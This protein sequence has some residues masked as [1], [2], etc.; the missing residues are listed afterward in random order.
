MEARMNLKSYFMHQQMMTKVLISLIPIACMSVWLYGWRNLIVFAVVT[1]AAVLAEYAVMHLVQKEKTKVTE[2]AIVTSALFTLTLPPATPVYVAVMGI[3]FGIVFAK[4]A[5][6]G[7]GRNI[8]NPAL[9]ARCFVYIAFPTAMTMQWSTPFQGFPGGL[10][11]YQTAVDGIT[12]STPMIAMEAGEAAP[13]LLQMLIGTHAGS[14]GETSILLIVIA[15][16]YLALTKTASWKIMVSSLLG[17]GILSA[18]VHFTG[19]STLGILPSLFTGGL[20]FAAIFMAT[21]PVTAPKDETA[22]WVCGTLFGIITVI[23]RTFS[24][25]T[26]GAMFAVLIVNAFT[27]L[28]E[29]NIKEIKNKKKQ[30][31]AAS[32]TPSKEVKA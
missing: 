19:H 26:E 25:F 23:I 14:M 15:G 1:L 12:S 18:I 28:I 9:V 5:F 32:K 31:A 27:P 29:R 7:F 22:K 16:L 8:F 10:A 21:D 4:A 11:A 2:A 6:G 3:V 24:L 30:K 20:F 13:E 17:A